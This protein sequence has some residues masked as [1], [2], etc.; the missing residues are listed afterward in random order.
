MLTRMTKNWGH[1]LPMSRM[2][3]DITTDLA[4][5]KKDSKGTLWAMFHT[6]IWQFRWNEPIL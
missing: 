2:K 4:D 3:Q 1:K 5:I 6:N